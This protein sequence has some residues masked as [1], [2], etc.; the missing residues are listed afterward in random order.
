MRYYHNMP[1]GMS[2][3]NV[4]QGFCCRGGGNTPM[5]SSV[6]R[7]IDCEYPLAMAYVPWQRWNEVYPIEKALCMGTL[8]P[9]LS[10]PFMG[11]QRRNQ[12]G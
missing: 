4:E 6:R 9:E 5:M 12:C 11:C 3:V 7:I 2:G 10:L 8:F 1:C